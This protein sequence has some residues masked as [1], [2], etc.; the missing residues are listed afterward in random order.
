MTR[1][2]TEI[3]FQADYIVYIKF[4]DI[5]NAVQK[6]LLHYVFLPHIKH[7][8]KSLRARNSHPF[9]SERNWTPEQLWANGTMDLR[10]YHVT[11]VAEVQESINSQTLEDLEWFRMDWYTPTPSDE[12]LSTIEEVLDVDV[13]F[14]DHVF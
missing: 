8:T 12:G 11:H 5:V 2:F 13:P 4:L 9:R 10:N 14:N 3:C 6:F 7:V 1:L